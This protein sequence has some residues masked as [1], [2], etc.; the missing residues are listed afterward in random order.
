[1]SG[2]TVLALCINLI[3][4]HCSSRAVFFCYV[5]A[6]N[7]SMLKQKLQKVIIFAGALCVLIG[8][9]FF[10][11]P[12]EVPL[13]ALFIPF[14][15]IYVVSYMIVHTFVSRFLTGKSEQLK[16]WLSIFVALLPVMLLVLQSSGQMSRSDLVL[17]GVLIVVLILYFRKTDFLQ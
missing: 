9:V 1:M 16:K 13:Y 8:F 17:F 14:I 4:K 11:H 15:A 12:A 3:K 5:V 7:N 6:Y 10:L 2:F